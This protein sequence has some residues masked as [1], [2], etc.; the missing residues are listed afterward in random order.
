MMPANKIKIAPPIQYGAH[1]ECWAAL[2]C[3]SGGVVTSVPACEWDFNNHRVVRRVIFG[4]EGEHRAG[5]IDTHGARRDVRTDNKLR[6]ANTHSTGRQLKV[7]RN[8]IDPIFKLVRQRLVTQNI[9][10]FRLF[11]DAEHA[12]GEGEGAGL[13]AGGRKVP[14][15]ANITVPRNLILA[16]TISRGERLTV[17]RR[18]QHFDPICFFR[19]QF[20]KDK[21]KRITDEGKGDCF[22]HQQRPIFLGD[23]IDDKAVR[24]I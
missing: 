14:G 22:G 4:C 1:C 9:S 21:G 16:G 2:A 23:D 18:R 6:F 8:G 7:D 3:H 11:N 12:I 17:N 20:A 24:M 13:I 5:V 15:D 19:Q 10:V